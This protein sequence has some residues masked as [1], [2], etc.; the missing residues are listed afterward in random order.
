M[1]RKDKKP[2]KVEE[3]RLP[4][5]VTLRLSYRDYLKLVEIGNVAGKMKESKDAKK[6]ISAVIGDFDE[7]LNSDKFLG[8]V[9]SLSIK[10][11]KSIERFYSQPPRAPPTKMYFTDPEKATNEVNELYNASKKWTRDKLRYD[12]TR[13][14]CPTDV[15]VMFYAYVRGKGLADDVT[16]E[17]KIDKFLKKVAPKALSGIKHIKRNNSSFI[18]EICSEIRGSKPK[19][20]KAKVEESEDE[21]SSE[22]EVPKKRKGK[23]V[24]E[25]EEE[26]SE[27][28]SSE[29]EAP[30]SKFKRR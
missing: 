12:Q 27:E 23:K 7:E 29:E 6:I 18:W 28:E 5:H 11:E 15:R 26:S 8:L 30:K 14:T 4:K 22:E 20:K 10:G 13:E 21:E 9:A 16:K 1:P 17:I 24:V 3:E 2:K 25:S 19:P